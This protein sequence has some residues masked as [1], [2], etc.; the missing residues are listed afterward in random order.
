L[1]ARNGP[2]QVDQEK[3]EMT[4]AHDERM[5]PS[6]RRLL[7]IRHGPPLISQDTPAH[8]WPL[9]AEGRQ[10]CQ[11]FAGRLAEYQVAAIISSAE[12]KARE[13]AAILAARLNL[14][15]GMDADLNEHRR[16]NVRLLGRLDFEAAA[17]RLFAEPDALV[18][19]QETATHAYTRFAGAVQRTLVAHP[20]GDVALVTHGTV[21]TLYAERHAGVEPF[22][23]WQALTLPDLVALAV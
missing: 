7:L 5:V 17:R 8:E 15:P 9:S 14:T 16:D 6:G 10:V 21:M 12:A 4:M 22:A 3:V 20:V 2:R 1:E 13:T 18:F 19:G 23:F 11:E